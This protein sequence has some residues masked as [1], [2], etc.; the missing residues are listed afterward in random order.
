MSIYERGSEWRKWDLHVHTPES[1][2][3]IG[4]WT[5]FKSQLTKADCDAIGINDYFSVAGYK[6]I[7]DEID[8][9]SLNI[10]DKYL[11]PIVEMRMTDSVQNKNTNTNGIT[12]FNFHIIFSDQINVDDIE[13]FIKSLK[14]EG[15][16][17]G[18]D[19]SDK[20]KLLNKKVSFA[21][22]LTLLN[23]D[24]KFK[25]N[26]LVWLPYDEYGGI[27]DIDPNSDGW[28]KSSFIKEDG[29]WKYLDGEL[30]NSKIE[31]NESC[32]CGSGKKFKKC[33]G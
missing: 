12:H 24:S 9:G 32:P 7:K 25:D 3:F 29:T 4:D 33:C 6:K 10:G 11:L 23:E 26:F 5:Q 16:T 27:D 22:T 20:K 30:Y 18:G 2:G 1:E 17:I 21:E 28:I 15:T 31:R 19:Y 13:N 14:T 8:N